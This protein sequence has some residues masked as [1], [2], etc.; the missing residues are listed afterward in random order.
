MSNPMNTLE[1]IERNNYVATEQ[2]IETAASERYVSDTA[3]RRTDQTYLRVI[4]VGCQAELGPAVARGR[5]RTPPPATKEAQTAVLERVHAKY[6]AAVLRGI[7]TPDVAPEEGLDDA[8]RQRRTLERNRRSTFA[9][10]AKATLLRY[11]ENGGDMRTLDVKEA[12]KFSLRKAVA[13]PESTDRNERQIARAEGMLIRALR[14]TARTNPEMAADQLERLLEEFQR[15]LD[16]MTGEGQPEPTATQVQP[17]RDF[18]ATTTVAGRRGGGPP[19]AGA[20]E[21][22]PML[23]RGA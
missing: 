15:E 6:Y 3:V 4:I 21:R 23:H 19:G 2:Q 8:E 20:G 13:P 5:R 7:T 1:R 17:A 14:R 9:R 22:A 18:G 10:S 11:V 16:A 12:T